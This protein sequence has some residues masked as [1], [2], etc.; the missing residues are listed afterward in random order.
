MSRAAL[1]GAQ[2]VM[3]DS[4]HRI[5]GMGCC[6]PAVACA[7]VFGEEARCDDV[8]SQIDAALERDIERGYLRPGAVACE[9]TPGSFSPNTDTDTVDD[10]LTQYRVACDEQARVC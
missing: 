5:L 1:L 10:L 8:T 2:S 7:G 9:L 4:T 6:F 3:A